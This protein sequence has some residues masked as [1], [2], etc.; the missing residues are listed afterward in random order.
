MSSPYVKVIPSKDRSA[1]EPSRIVQ[2]WDNPNVRVWES[3]PLEP[4][5][6]RFVANT[7]DRILQDEF[8]IHPIYS[9]LEA[10]V[11]Q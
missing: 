5:R 10:V 9:A 7:L 4:S 2:L 3:R 8:S 1:G 6:A 11:I